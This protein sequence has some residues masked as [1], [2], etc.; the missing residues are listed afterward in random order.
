MIGFEDVTLSWGG[1]DYVVPANEQLELIARLE[2]A[3]SD[4]GGHSAVVRLMQPGGPSTARLAKGYGAA[5]RYA[6]AKVTDNDVYLRIDEDLAGAG[7]DFHIKVTGYIMG[8]LAIM[9]PHTASKIAALT[10]GG[11]AGKKPTETDAA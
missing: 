11:D 10:G 5:L 7:G 3:I 2:A 8:L 1:E 9:S 6:G 4:E